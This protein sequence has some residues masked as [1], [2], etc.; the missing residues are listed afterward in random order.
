[1]SPLREAL[2]DYL[3]VRR[4]LGFELKAHGRLLEDFVDFLERAG[5][6]HVTTELTVA[7]AKLPADARP[8]YWRQ[9]LG[10]C[11]RSRATWQRSTPRA[12]CPPRICCPPPSSATRKP[13][14][15]P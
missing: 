14:L 5:A 4:R 11:A 8:H 7:W 12:R 10:S 13:R 3:R 2:N 6:Q 15:T 1:M 9:R